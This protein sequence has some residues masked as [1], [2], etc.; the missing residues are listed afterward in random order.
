MGELLEKATR[1]STESDS[2]HLEMQQLMA[3]DEGYYYRFNAPLGYDL[4]LSDW[5]ISQTHPITTTFN[6]K[7]SIKEYLGKK[8][9]KAQVEKC[10]RQLIEKRHR[11]EEE[12]AARWDRFASEQ[13]SESRQESES[14]SLSPVSPVS[15]V[16]P[17]IKPV[18]PVTPVEP[19]R[20]ISL[21]SWSPGS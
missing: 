18:R 3:L 10:A 17:S 13:V 12:D 9:M 6:L 5:G 7:K 4:S 21:E 8:E 16:L 20:P 14:R 1:F 2:T 19:N 15:T 11:R